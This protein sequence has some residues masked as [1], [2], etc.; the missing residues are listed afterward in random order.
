M[1]RTL[2]LAVSAGLV[3]VS[4]AA[5]QTAPWQFRPPV[6]QPLTYRVEHITSVTEVAGGNK[7]VT[8]T[9]VNLVKTWKNAGTDIGKPGVK[10]VLT[11][12][13]LRLETAKPSGE[14]LLFDSEH[15]DKSTPALREQLGK[16]VGQVMAVVRLDPSGRVMEVIESKQGSASR[17]EN[18]PPF[19]VVLPGAAP[20]AGQGWERTYRLTLDPPQGTGEK[21]D[22]VQK[23]VCKEIKD[24]KAT[25]GLTTQVKNLP[26]SPLDQVPLH[27]AQPEGEIVFDIE[28][29]RLHSSQLKIDKELKGLQ[30]EGSSYHFESLFTEQYVAN[31]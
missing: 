25:I 15:P 28:A 16:L 7:T 31:P 22:A 18:E 19:Q 27:Q 12:N 10:M 6:G 8:T 2:L 29:G 1:V 30:G 23:Y 13:A 5:A 14:V 4:A 11:L 17:F 24:G 26:A 3:A 20:T 21:F 9:K